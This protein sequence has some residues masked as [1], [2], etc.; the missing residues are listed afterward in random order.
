MVKDKVQGEG[1]MS[2]FKIKVQDHG[3]RSGFKIKVQKVK[4]QNSGGDSL[5]S[6]AHKAG[7]KVPRGS[8][9]RRSAV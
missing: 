4:D 1:S 2:W 5:E 3:S 8:T 7:I 6:R 9:G